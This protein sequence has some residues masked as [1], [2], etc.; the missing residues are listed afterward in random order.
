M[1]ELYRALIVVL[2]MG[3]ASQWLAR[4]ALV[5]H[6]PGTKAEKSGTPPDFWR[7]WAIIT[8]F[9]FLAHD[10]WIFLGA[11]SLYLIAIRRHEGSSIALFLAVILMMPPV[12]RDLPTFGLV[13]HLL[14]LDLAAVAGLLLLG[15]DLLKKDKTRTKVARPWVLLYVIWLV[16]LAF[17]AA[18]FTSFLRDT[19]EILLAVALPFEGARRSVRNPVDLKRICELY[20]TMCL[21]L[22]VLATFEHARAWL[23]FHEV[24]GALGSP[25]A[26]GNYLA[27][28]GDLRAE[29]TT[30]QPIVLGYV[31]AIGLVL[32]QSTEI[33]RGK[34]TSRKFVILILIAGLYSSLSRGPWIGAAAGIFA[35]SLLGKHG[36]RRGL[37]LAS[38]GV[39]AL[40]AAPFLPGGQKLLNLL[41]FIGTTESDTVSY[42]QDLFHAVTPLLIDSPIFGIPDYNH[43]PELQ[44]LRQG[45]GI[46]DLVN[47]YIQVGVASGFVG[48]SFFL[49]AHG[50]VMIGLLEMVRRQTDEH[51]DLLR[52]FLAAYITAM[53]TIATTSNISYIPV[54]YWAFLGVGSALIGLDRVAR[55][56]VPAARP[57]AHI[58]P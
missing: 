7:V 42:R 3:L 5:P 26:L 14:P 54:I 22:A 48:L 56:R 46:I 32:A 17:F 53:V 1:P 44:F 39:A 51:Q 45:E 19:S 9:G 38:A 11:T 30:G 34:L 57:R 20:L 13:Q 10:T 21:T 55:A 29:V 18:N 37:Q 16:V 8:L 23:L 40:I 28:G 6:F 47:T 2:V 49:L 15:P 35:F 43:R 12:S 52:G 31:I 24:P 36:L 33:Y 58:S 41:P 4:A 50:T 27:R 25:F